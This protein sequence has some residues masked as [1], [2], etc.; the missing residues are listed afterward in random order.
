MK[1][2]SVRRERD[3]YLFGVERQEDRG[4]DV[5]ETSNSGH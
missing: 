5:K 1:K 3:T 2:S 4:D